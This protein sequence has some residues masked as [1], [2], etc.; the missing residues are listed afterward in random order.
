[1]YEFILQIAVTTVNHVLGIAAMLEV[2]NYVGIRVIGV[3]ENGGGGMIGFDLV[4]AA[5]PIVGIGVPVGGIV[6]E[7][8]GFQPSPKPL[9]GRIGT[10]RS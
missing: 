7:I 2:V 10:D 9:M 1:M 4:Q 6:L 5:G 3:V 8:E